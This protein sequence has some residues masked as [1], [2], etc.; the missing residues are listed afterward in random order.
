MTREVAHFQQFSAALSTIEP[1]FPPGV[2]QGD[3]RFT[4]AYFNM[5]HEEDARGP[6]NE[7]SGPWPE[8]EEWEYIED[9]VSQVQ[10]TGGQEEKVA[11]GHERDEKA[12]KRE[13]KRLAKQRSME[14]KQPGRN[15]GLQWSTYAGN[16][17]E[18]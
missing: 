5:S 18:E 8:G 2:M 17:T 10:E 6:W 7:G 16:G 1:N 15:G 13:E 14:V 4:H 3:P 11:V 12:L 9:P